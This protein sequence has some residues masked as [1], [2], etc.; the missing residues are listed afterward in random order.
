[1]NRDQYI[2]Q[3]VQKDPILDAIADSIEQSGLPSISVER[4]IGQLLTLLVSSNRTNQALE[5]G[6][7]GGYS[8][9]CIARGL[10]PRGRLTTLEIREEHAELAK[11][12]F[13]LAGVGDNVDVFV[14]EAVHSLE[15]LLQ[16]N[17]AFDFIFI[18]ADKPNYP[19]YLEYALKLSRPGTI[20]VADNVFLSDK[21]MDSN[22]LNP[23]PTAMRAFNT[24]FLSHPRL[25]A[26]ILPL[27][28]GLAMG[29]VLP[30]SIY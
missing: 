26:T 6:T 24:V 17:R 1:M 23:S 29:Q 8:G 15:T 21:V 2:Q 20:I 22:N 25:L 3:L 19:N 9:T 30:E 7:L 13:A 16:T 14:G 18:D 5:I 4:Q 12:N 27:Y 28:D 11:Q 10:A